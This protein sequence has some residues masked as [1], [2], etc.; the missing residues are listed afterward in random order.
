MAILNQYTLIEF[1]FNHYN[2]ALFNRQLK[3]HFIDMKKGLIGF[4]FPENADKLW[5]KP[6]MKIRCETCDK[7]FIEQNSSKGNNKEAKS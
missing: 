4:I 7:R 1:I 2:K 3:Y 6:G 5:G